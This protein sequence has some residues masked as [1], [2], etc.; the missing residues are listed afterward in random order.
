[1]IKLHS[2]VIEEFRGI[3]KLRLD[4]GGKNFAVH[5]P[6]GTG[7]SGVVDAIEFALTGN[8]T[9]LTGQGTS[10][11]SLKAHAPHV[12]QR[13]A[14]ERTR[15]ILQ[16]YAPSLK[17]NVTI[18]RRVTNPNTPTITPDEPDVRR[19]VAELALHPEF[20]LTRREIIKY[21]LAPP[22]ERAK[23]VQALLRLEEIEKV[24]Q[25]FQSI[26][27]LAK[28]D[29]KRTEQE[30]NQAQLQLLRALGIPVLKRD[31]LLKVVNQRRELLGLE[32][33]TDLTAN[34]S[35]KVGMGGTS[36]AATKLAV[37]KKQALADVGSLATRLAA[38]EESDLT[39]ARSETKAALETLVQSPSLLRSLKTEH[40][41]RSGLDLVEDDQC[42]F[43][44][45]EWDVNA[46]REHV[47]AKLAQAKTASELR[48]K[49][50]SS[51]QALVAELLDLAT[52]A[53][54]TVKYARALPEALGM[55]A[56]ITWIET[57]KNKRQAL[58][59][60]RD[61]EGSIAIVSNAMH[62][63]PAKMDEEI[64]EL[65][66]RISSLP[67]VSQED[68]AK[69]FLTVAQERL[70]VHR[71]A[72]RQQD[73]SN[74]QSELSG[75]VLTAFNES[76]NTVLTGI[77][78][79]VQEDFSN[80]Y[81]FINREDE[82]TFSGKLVPSF[83][84]LGFDVDF[85]GRGFFPPGAY[86]SE[87]HQ[88]SMGI[89]LYLALMRHMLGSQFTFS[90]LDDILMSVDSRHRREVCS[91]LKSQFPET[92]FIVTTH[93][94]IWL[95]HLKTEQLITS[96]AFVQFRKWTVD[97]GP[98]VWEGGEMWQEIQNDLDNND[99]PAASQ[100]LRRYLEYI[101]AQ[102]SSKLRASVEY[103]ADAQHD[104]GEFLPAV[105]GKW[106]SL[107]SHAKDAAQSWGKKD[108]ISELS[109]RQIEF[110]QR[111]EKTNIERWPINKTIHYNE[112]V[113]LQ[114]HDF[115]PVIDAFKNLLDA[116]RCSKCQSFMY[117]IP[118]RG[119]IEGLRCDCGSVNINLKRRPKLP[120]LAGV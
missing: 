3:R 49:I 44:D 63:H 116:F 55:Q 68:E 54:D 90:V 17:K 91:L 33:L 109:Q 51:S 46:L 13:S 64:V 77:Y 24:R 76:A 30:T 14:P 99:V 31:E 65:Q 69:E 72:K 38:T 27:N 23:E 108:E 10:N 12:D 120:S 41:L 79:D 95:N 21:V 61:I 34:T 85:Y 107:L 40:F 59:S 110:G 57:L 7:K 93:D 56:V 62:E 87:G 102:L 50:L 48:Q 66:T 118:A 1:M 58:A 32:A 28:A 115:L 98:H 9:R 88:D 103:R 47:E 117:V 20:A 105:V 60:S 42:P 22:G 52:V 111:F 81:K 106:N 43:C 84:K 74:K 4:F 100:T 89:C 104:L 94:E 92:Q 18:E 82:A 5:G 53:N 112:W 70:D 35:L 83:G 67:D 86:H 11:I 16:A 25:S 114:K 2:L 8:I 29:A 19:V 36:S 6:N 45:R 73:R 26:H 101:S 37:P 71:E 97:D 96:K 113:S 119:E 15:V 78:H 80:F 39:K 75:K